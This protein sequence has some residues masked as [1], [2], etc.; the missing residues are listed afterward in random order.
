[1]GGSVSLPC[2]L[3]QLITAR[4]P[5]FLNGTGFAKQEVYIQINI[6]KIIRP[7]TKKNKNKKHGA[8]NQQ[9]K[10]KDKRIVHLCQALWVLVRLPGSLEKH[11]G[12]WPGPF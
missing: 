3:T 7:C 6:E 4:S 11:P 8:W 5:E 9:S 12:A 1:M 10:K 2:A